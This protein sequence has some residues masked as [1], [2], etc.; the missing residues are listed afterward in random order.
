MRE[1]ANKEIREAL[2]KYDV[3]AWELADRLG[4]FASALSVK[5][6]YELDPKEK[7]KLIKIIKEIA[8]EN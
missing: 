5:F 7:A 2:K 3:K 6:R 4:I 8:S 1:K